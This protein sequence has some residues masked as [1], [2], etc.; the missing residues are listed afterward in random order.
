MFS[1]ES[2]HKYFT[3][4]KRLVGGDVSSSGVDDVSGSGVDDVSGSGVDYT[5]IMLTTQV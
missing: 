5:S 2:L 4:C 1:I 3:C